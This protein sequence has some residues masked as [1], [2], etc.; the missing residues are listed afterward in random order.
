MLIVM[1][2]MAVTTLCRLNLSI[3]GKYIAEEFSFD[4]IT[5]GHVFSA[6]LWG[7]GFFQV[8]WGYI[9]DR[10][11]PRRTLA[12]AMLLFCV[13]AALMP[14]AP[15]LALRTGISVL[16]A[17]QI[18]RFFTGLGEAAI[19]ANVTRVI[20]SWTAVR[21]RGFASGLQTAGLGLG[22]TMTPIFISW[23]MVH[24]GWRVSFYLCSFLGFLVLLMWWFY[25][26]DWPEEHPDIS[27][28]ELE[29][30]HP[31][32]RSRVRTPKTHGERRAVPWG[33][34]LS[35]ASIWGLIL[36]YGCQGYAFYVYYNWFYF[37]AVK[38]RGLG[39]LQAA[40]WTSFPFLAMATLSPVGGWFS[41]RV[42]KNFG[43]RRGR[44]VAVWVGMGLSAS[45]LYAGSHTTNTSFALPMMALAAGFLMFAGANF[46]AACIDLAP[47]H[48]A[49]LSA[50]MNTLASVGGAISST[51]TPY[52]A[53]RH[54]WAQALDLAAF[55]TI[56]SGLL[57]IFVDAGTSVE[58]AD[59]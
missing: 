40:I 11:G 31:G 5:M 32:A 25:S 52:I 15:R 51:V 55:I 29:L 17:F 21:E 24:W 27:A 9:G 35:S 13:G 41:D 12:T 39:I 23:T 2:I 48:S 22:G 33:R 44:Q 59:S 3:A 43:R 38:V 50:M 4:T 34:L 8:P 46:W 7:Y 57:W 42:A 58:K 37:Y 47:N 54:S 56:V 14:V 10:Y 20:A 26:T 18:I 45:L 19:S 6:F 36:G 49:T 28:T 16:L 30:I 53:T 1:F